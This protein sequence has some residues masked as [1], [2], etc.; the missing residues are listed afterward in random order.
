MNS[1]SGRLWW[2]AVYVSAT[3]FP[4]TSSVFKACRTS[5]PPVCNCAVCSCKTYTKFTR[6]KPNRNN[7]PCMGEARSSLWQSPSKSNL[8]L[9]CSI[10]LSLYRNDSIISLTLEKIFLSNP[11][12]PSPILHESLQEC[13]NIEGPIPIEI[14]QKTLSTGDP[15]E[16]TTFAKIW[17]ATQSRLTRTL[18]DS[19]LH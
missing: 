14:T 10:A 8:I 9:L 11:F 16:G 18:N 3:I 12:G 13:T 1:Q 4:K 17:P 15:L 2:D 7:F 19:L 5:I 6:H